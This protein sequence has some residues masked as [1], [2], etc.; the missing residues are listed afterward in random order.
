MLDCLDSFKTGDC[1]CGDAPCGCGRRKV[2][3]SDSRGGCT[4]VLHDPDHVFGPHACA[5]KGGTMTIKAPAYELTVE[6]PPDDVLR[7]TDGKPVLVD[8]NSVAKGA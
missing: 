8:G 1:G 6:N 7:G 2:L 3:V 4:P 5:A